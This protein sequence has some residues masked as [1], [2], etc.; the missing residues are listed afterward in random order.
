MT[1]TKTRALANWPNNAVSVLDYGA[2]GDGV[3]DDTA[4]IQAALDA[5]TQVYIPP[6]RY[7]ITDVL[8]VRTNSHVIGGGT[9]ELYPDNASNKPTILAWDDNPPASSKGNWTDIG[10]GEDDP[11]FAPAL[12]LSGPNTCITDLT[13]LSQSN[14]HAGVFIPGTESH[15]IQG[16]KINGNPKAGLYVDATWSDRNTTLINARGSE[17][18]PSPGPVEIIVSDCYLR[19]KWAMYIKGSSRDSAADNILKDDWVWGYNGTSDISVVS[20]QFR[21][22]SSSLAPGDTN[23][24]GQFYMSAKGSFAD[25]TNNEFRGPKF[26]NCVFRTNSSF[27]A[28]ID[29]AKEIAFTNLTGETGGVYRDDKGN[30]WFEVTSNCRSVS[31][32]NSSLQFLQWAQDGVADPGGNRWTYNKNKVPILVTDNTQGFISSPVIY[33]DYRTTNSP[34]KIFG[35]EGGQGVHLMDASLDTPKVVFQAYNDGGTPTI[36]TGDNVEFGTS[37]STKELL[38]KSGNTP[39][40]SIQEVSFGNGRLVID[41]SIAPRTDSGAGLGTS[42]LAWG[43]VYANTYNVKVN[44]SSTFAEIQSGNGNPNGNVTAPA[45]S[46]YLNN[47]GGANN[48]LWVKETTGNTNTGWVAK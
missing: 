37:F 34:T 40:F 26:V 2:V 32:D 10:E 15:R 38:F 5:S 22:A 1:R 42:G 25:Y 46:L 20:T 3:T 8:Y 16:C 12:V 41:N 28:Y 11:E 7:R 4:A 18:T 31:L 45:G 24:G 17:I 27:H 19:G 36:R 14:W 35:G 6:A 30:S 44:G 48:T 39:V 29:W 43:G 23:G 9:C 21:A 33:S 13:I 47:D